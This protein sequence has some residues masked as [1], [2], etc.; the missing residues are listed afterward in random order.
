MGPDYT[1]V[2]RPLRSRPQ[3]LRRRGPSTCRP[4]PFCGLLRGR[5]RQHRSTADE[6]V[7]ATTS[8][9]AKFNVAGSQTQAV[10]GRA[11]STSPCPAARSCA[12]HSLGAS[13]TGKKK[14]ADKIKQVTFFVNDAK[15]K[16][17]KTPDKGDA[18]NL[19]V[20]DDGPRTSGP[21]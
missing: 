8:V 14:R 2:L 5:G 11:R 12:T 10:S 13:V 3:V 1:P 18:V 7:S 15:V 20:A 4:A 6:T 21:R 16:K 19:P 9:H 17:V